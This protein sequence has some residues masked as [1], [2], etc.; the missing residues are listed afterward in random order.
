MTHC[1]AA[2]AVACVVVVVSQVLLNVRTKDQHRC[3]RQLPAKTRGHFRPTACK[4][5]SDHSERRR[6][7]GR[8]NSTGT[9][10]FSRRGR[11]L[12]ICRAWHMMAT[13]GYWSELERLES[14]RMCLCSGLRVVRWSCVGRGGHVGCYTMLVTKAG[15]CRR[16]RWPG[17]W[18]TERGQMIQH[19]HDIQHFGCTECGVF[20][21][22]PA[23]CSAETPWRRKGPQLG[24]R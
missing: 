9:A 14:A 12:R 13:G 23:I 10:C 20:D 1:F 8:H 11:N 18:S 22:G 3:L 19:W 24:G 2:L 7:E 6:G 15:W 16:R 5:H 21:P 4:G 17:D